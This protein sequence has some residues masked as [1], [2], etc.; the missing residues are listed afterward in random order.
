MQCEKCHNPS[1]FPVCYECSNPQE[2]ITYYYRRNEDFIYGL[3]LKRQLYQPIDNLDLDVHRNEC[4]K[5]YELL[6][7]LE[8]KDKNYL[9]LGC[10]N[11]FFP[12]HLNWGYCLGIDHSKDDIILATK[13]RNF[14][15]LDEN[16]I[17]FLTSEINPYNIA[18]M[19]IEVD[20]VTVLSIYH[21]W[22]NKFG[23][24]GA[25]IM[26]R[27][28]FTAKHIIIEQGFITYEQFVEWTGVEDF[29]RHEFVM[30]NP[31]IM[32]LLVKAAIGFVPKFEILGHTN[33]TQSN[34]ESYDRVII[35]Y[36][37]DE[38][39]NKLSIH[40]NGQSNALYKHGDR[41]FKYIPNVHKRIADANGNQLL[42]RQIV[43][44]G[45]VFSM[46][47]YKPTTKTYTIAEEADML[48]DG[49]KRLKESDIIHNEFFKNGIFTDERFEPLDFETATIHDDK[50][51]TV[52]RIQE[53]DINAIANNFEIHYFRYLAKKYIGTSGMNDLIKEYILWKKSINNV[54]RTL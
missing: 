51:D 12:L 35:H 42:G 11:G 44:H 18:Q 9:D 46:P 41:M 3:P 24:D 40:D 43:K 48:L 39:F 5:R 53:I 52:L 49:L 14:M 17:K 50:A 30:A 1:E 45:D 47:Y 25:K 20:I 8:F 31:I 22:M 27:Y 23:I 26:L 13:T 32:H 29:G 36:I 34:G 2:F 37:M 38:E 16:K 6:K 28:V 19:M 33:Y 4:Y 15:E 10:A 21:H 7:L 54:C